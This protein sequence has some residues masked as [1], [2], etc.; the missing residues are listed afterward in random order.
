[1]SNSGF[2][3]NIDPK[4]IRYLEI[5]GLPAATAAATDDPWA[6]RLYVVRLKSRVYQ[7]I[8][9]SKAAL[10]ERDRTFFNAVSTFRP[11]T[12]AEVE[13]PKGRTF[14]W[15]IIEIEAAGF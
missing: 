6:F 14:T 13:C 3:K 8:F 4:S 12:L 10:S 1:V 5:N 2:I 9:A 7:F 11:L 15:R